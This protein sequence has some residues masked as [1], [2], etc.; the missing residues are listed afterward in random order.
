MEWTLWRLSLSSS[1]ENVSEHFLPSYIM[2]LSYILTYFYLDDS[3]RLKETT[4]QIAEATLFS[5]NCNI[6]L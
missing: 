2:K 4:P 1:A 5:R 3:V 6:V